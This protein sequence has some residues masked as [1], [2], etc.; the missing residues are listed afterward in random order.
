[1]SE[2]SAPRARGYR[3]ECHIRQP[4]LQQLKLRSP[5]AEKGAGARKGMT[6]R[7]AGDTLVPGPVLPRPRGRA[8]D[9]RR[10]FAGVAER[11]VF[12]AVDGAVSEALIL[13]GVGVG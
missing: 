6:V 11:H 12:G 5:F 10:R 13:R 4:G 1:M 9:G 3:A 7:A 8:I 2:I